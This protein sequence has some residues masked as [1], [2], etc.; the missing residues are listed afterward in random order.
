[1]YF[2]NR[3]VPANANLTI[4]AI[5]DKKVYHA[6]AYPPL[7]PHP[8]GPNSF[9][10]AYVFANGVGAPNRKYSILPC[11]AYVVVIV[12]NGRKNNKKEKTSET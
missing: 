11:Y 4:C 10:F 3:S 2:H 9:V 5:I 1:M 6:L 7:P 12:V 8:T